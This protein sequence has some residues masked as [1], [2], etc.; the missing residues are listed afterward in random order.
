MGARSGGGAGGG[1]GSRSGG[2]GGSAIPN[3]PT[4][5][6]SVKNSI[7][8][9]SRTDKWNKNT[10][11]NMGF[12]DDVQGAIEKLAKGDYGFPSQVAKSVTSRPG[13]KQNGAT[14]SEKQAY[15]LAKGII[16]NKLAQPTGAF[17]NAK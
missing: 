9:Y 4:A 11:Y 10:A 8:S 7:M 14:V 2:G 13:W 12:N 6:Q 3:T 5:I 16:D 15:H 17:A 1:M